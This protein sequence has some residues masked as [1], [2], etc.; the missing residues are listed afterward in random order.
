M[1]KLTVNWS[2][3]STLFTL[4]ALA[5]L[6]LMQIWLISR[7][8]MIPG[9]R[10][11]V[12]LV[13]NL[14]LWLLLAGF[15]LQARWTVSSGTTHALLAGD[16][17]PRSYLR[18]VRDSLSVRETY[19]P[20]D[21]KTGQF[22]GQRFDQVTLIGQNIDAETLSR[23][24]RQQL[25]WFPYY[26][27]DQIQDIHWKGVVRK[28]DRQRISGRIRSSKQQWLKVNYGNRTLDSL[29]LPAGNTAFTLQF[30][31]FSTGRTVTE[32][33]LD[34][35][36]V[37]TLHFFTQRAEPL[38]YQF[39]LG[40]PDFE[41]KTLADWLG[42]Q[43]HSVQVQATLSKNISSSLHINS[44]AGKPDIVITDPDHAG[45]P[46][47]KR[48]IA[49]GKSVLFINL[50]EPEANSIAINRA[51]GSTWKLRRVS[52]EQTVSIGNGLQALP[53]TIAGALN[54]VPIPGYPAAVQQMGGK[55]GLSLVSETF[56]LRLGGDSIAYD[57][58]WT[59]ILNPL[60][61]SQQNNVQV[62]APLFA[63][64][65]T[66]LRINN[67]ATPVAAV[68]IAADT[69]AVLPS[70]LNE[71]TFRT[72]YRLAQPGWHRWQDTLE[73]YA[74]AGNRPASV[75]QPTLISRY[76]AAHTRY[77]VP[78]TAVAP[79]ADK[80]VPGWVWLMLFLMVF[81]ALWV[82]PKIG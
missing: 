45:H 22:D 79:W 65:A 44:K 73:V 55:V 24:S 39:I 5:A 31:A 11:G 15:V 32:L 17:V 56:P 71:R 18:Q 25:R 43:G 47:V 54:Q 6:L 12:R 3:T 62:E 57:R 51:L 40:S 60:R 78:A 42:K 33:V 34:Q 52:S 7:N 1:I 38:R 48:A 16:D 28:G 21:V 23:L 8:R 37:D 10:K 13:L 2:E 50:A 75:Y 36:V 46:V 66:S 80:K 69:V 76:I 53:Y 72:R 14:V 77:P 29:E 59:T 61:P 20:D 35:Q 58:I 27:P 70:P 4:L 67:P 68:R 74:E 64:L 41:S 9:R 19:T 63:G 49:D 81:T 26:A 82:E 30:P